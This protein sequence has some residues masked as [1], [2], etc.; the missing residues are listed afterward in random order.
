M[1]L[2]KTIEK[3]RIFGG[4]LRP[5]IFAKL[6]PPLYSPVRRWGSNVHP[7]SRAGA[8][9]LRL[10]QAIC[11]EGTTNYRF[12]WRFS[13]VKTRGEITLIIGTQS[14]IFLGY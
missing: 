10:A 11:G 6:G 8:L 2:P 4:L 1:K 12:Y 3:A 5:K 7:Q 9:C 13:L 14:H